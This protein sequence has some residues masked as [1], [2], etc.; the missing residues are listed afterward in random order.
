MRL[1]TWL[2]RPIVWLPISIGLLAL[3]VWRSRIWEAG[4]SLAGLD[5]RPIAAAVLLSVVVAILWAVR[6]A[7]LLAAADRTVGVLQLVPMTTF[8]NTINNLTPGSAGEI[9][10]MYLLRAHHGIDYATSGAVV[11]VERVGAIGYLVSSALIAWLTWLGILPLSIAI[12]LALALVVAPAVAYRLGLRPLAVIRRIPLARLVGARRW[13]R[14]GDWLNRVDATI[15]ILVGDPRHLA[16]FVVLSGGIFLVYDAQLLL[17]G[18]ALGV[19]VDPLAAW[20][21]LGLATMIGVLSLLPFGLGST[22]LALVALLG[23][24]GVPTVDAVAMTFGYRIVSTLPLSIGGIA[25][26][27][28]LSAR[29]PATGMSG[30]ARAVRAELGDGVPDFAVDP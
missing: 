13:G 11:L 22:D 9:V 23:V 2:R 25:S 7:D 5:P 14:V 19:T 26:F 4:S 6:S 12:L 29:L 17:V 27:A 3:L 20:G 30:A 15:A 8:A 16:T 1:A 21:A 10:R 28:W 24:A 18:R